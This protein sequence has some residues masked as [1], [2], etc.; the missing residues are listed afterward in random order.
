MGY[1]IPWRTEKQFLLGGNAIF[2]LESTKTG[3]RYTYKVVTQKYRPENCLVKLLIGENNLE[4]YKVL[5]AFNKKTLE[6]HNFNFLAQE[7]YPVKAIMYFLSH[8]DNLPSNLNVYH[9]G[10]CCFCGRELT[11]PEALRR[12]YGRKCAK[13]KGLPYR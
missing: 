9:Q 13:A 1:K 6:Y 3:R 5:G 2:T 4:D 12:G 7:A 11:T 10:K 8:I